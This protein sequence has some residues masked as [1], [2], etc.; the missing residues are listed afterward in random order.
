MADKVATW[1]LN[2]E[3]NVAAKSAEDRAELEA[4]R[5]KI[6]ASQVALKGYQG[7]LRALQGTSDAVVK[8]KEALKARIEAEKG[9]LSQATQ[10]VLRHGQTY[11][12]LQAKMKAAEAA[13]R[14]LDAKAHRDEVKRVAEETKKLHEVQSKWAE[15]LKAAGGPLGE[16]HGKLSSYRELAGGTGG[17]MGAMGLAV[18]AVTAGVVALTAA[19]VA[20]AIKLGAFVVGAADSLRTM[21]LLREAVAGSAENARNLGTQVDAMARKV[22]TSKTALN[23]LAVSL[24]KSLSGGVSKASGQAIVDTFAAVSQAAAAAGDDTGRA[25]RDL[26]ERGK[27]VGR[28]WANPFELQGTGLQFQDIAKALSKNLKIG[29]DQARDALFNGR[30][31]LEAG[32]AALRTAVEAKFGNV[33]A[34]RLLSIDVQLE[35][36]H[37]RL[38]GLAKGVVLEP[39]LRG[40]SGLLE[41]FDETSV[42]GQSIAQLFTKIGQAIV[43]FSITHIDAVVHGIEQLVVWAQEATEFFQRWS[44][45]IEAVSDA[46]AKNETAMTAL[47]IV[48]AG[49]LAT[50]AAVGVAIGAVAAGVAGTLAIVGAPFY[51]LYKGFQFVNGLD[52][53][54]LGVAVLDGLTFGLSSNAIKLYDTIAGIAGKAKDAFKKILGIASPSKVFADYG[55]MTVA[56]YTQGLDRESPKAQ[57]SVAAMAPAPPRAGGLGARSVGA[58]AGGSLPPVVM[59]FHLPANATPDQAK[60]V[61]KAVTAPSILRELTRALREASITQGIPTQALVTSP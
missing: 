13:Q 37:E 57:E 34:S 14:K 11:E 17:A 31:S 12:Q 45:R 49:I 58:A 28:F 2:L 47:K 16:L 8:T 38:T 50:V 41:K 1:A 20:G 15:G 48:G 55:R 10:Q 33:N 3:G 5:V 36:F 25:L 39:L 44:A 43:S 32:A 7:S 6:E 46:F 52:W 42:T 24:T 29:L 21:G 60:E 18:G 23:E 53:K 22:A 40:L 26:V 30:V 61:A 56:G 54:S 19:V 27:V 59:H 9:A 4:L 51:A 35:K